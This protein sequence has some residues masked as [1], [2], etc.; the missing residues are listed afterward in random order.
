MRTRTRVSN[1][2]SKKKVKAHDPVIIKVK[3]MRGGKAHLIEEE[4]NTMVELT[5]QRTI[6]E[7]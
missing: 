7:Q 4:D 5:L 3:K 2:S 1:N 6:E